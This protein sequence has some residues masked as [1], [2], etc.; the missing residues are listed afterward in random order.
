MSDQGK[1]R[2]YQDHFPHD[3][4]GVEEHVVEVDNVSVTRVRARCPNGYR[5]LSPACRTNISK[6]VPF[7]TA[8]A[9]EAAD[10]MM[11]RAAARNMPVVIM[12]AKSWDEFVNI[13]KAHKTM[14][15][16]VGSRCDLSEPN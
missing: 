6:C 1:V 12:V 7:M 8:P 13:S 11:Q 9:G 5:W 16:L 10:F 2:P 4:E 15:E 3:T 14:V